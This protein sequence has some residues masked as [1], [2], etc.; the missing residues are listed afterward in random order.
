MRDAFKVHKNESMDDLLEEWKEFFF[1]DGLF[2]LFGMLDD[3]AFF[4]KLC[5][6]LNRVTILIWFILTYLEEVRMDE[7]G[8]DL[9]FLEHLLFLLIW[10][11][12]DN[13][14]DQKCLFYVLDHKYAWGFALVKQFVHF[15]VILL[16]THLHEGNVCGMRKVIDIVR[17]RLFYN[18]FAILMLLKKKIYAIQ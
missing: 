16:F 13:F 17:Q 9:Q 7:I 18:F 10:V 1:L 4:T 8:K 14:H 15:E 2:T 11:D 6:D 5:D 12:F 3:I